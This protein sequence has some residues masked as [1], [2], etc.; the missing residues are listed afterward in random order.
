M[1]NICDICNILDIFVKR[2]WTSLQM[3]LYKWSITI[4]IIIIKYTSK[5]YVEV[6]LSLSNASVLTQGSLHDATLQAE[7]IILYL[8]CGWRSSLNIRS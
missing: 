1:N 6:S 3:V 2:Y 8:S 7:L 4:I 5:A